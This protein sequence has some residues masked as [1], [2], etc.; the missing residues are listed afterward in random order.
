M[1]MSN[2]L[3]HPEIKKRMES[4]LGQLVD[5]DWP[6]ARQMKVRVSITNLIT[7]SERAGFHLGKR[8]AS[9]EAVLE[10]LK[11][12]MTGIE[13]LKADAG[14]ENKTSHQAYGEALAKIELLICLLGG[15]IERGEIGS[16]KTVSVE[17]EDAA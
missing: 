10:A 7:M 4:L 5:P 15:Q 9:R 3:Q 17:K 8:E 13:G 2:L 1:T 12:V 14:V 6:T 16:L 11:M